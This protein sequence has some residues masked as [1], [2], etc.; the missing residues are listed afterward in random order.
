IDTYDP[1]TGSASFWVRIPTLSH[2][3]ETAI[4][5]WYGNS[6]IST[7]QENK[8]GAWRNYVAVYHFGSGTTL[9][10]N[11]SSASSNNLTNSGTT[12][13]AGQI[14]GAIAGSSSGY[15]YKISPA[16]LPTG[17]NPRTIEAWF[18]FP[19][20]PNTS[21][22]IF[23]YG[24]QTNGKAFQWYYPNNNS[25][26]IDEYVYGQG[27]SWT[28]DTNWHHLAGTLPA[29]QTSSTGTLMY[30]DGRQQAGINPSVGTLN[31]GNAFIGVNYDNWWS[32][33]GNAIVDEYRISSVARS[34]DWF[35]TEYNNQRSPAQFLVSC[36]EA[37]GGATVAAC[38]LS[39]SP[40]GFSYTR[41]IVIDHTKVSNTDQ[42]DF[43]ILISGTFS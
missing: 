22:P 38:S 2:T 6:S 40:S 3:T 26:A 24:D 29:G 14:G 13:T 23:S 25:L 32:A 5:M 36:P 33:H 35:A 37:S 1:V 34:A 4:Y 7:S 31:T 42:T 18:R 12:I 16:N 43:P 20:N 8:A 17:T 28:F 11:D 21:V 30:F 9:S 19:S 39:L 27:F 41:P 10:L 15:A